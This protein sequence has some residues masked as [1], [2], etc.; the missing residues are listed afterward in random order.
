MV[1][2][3]KVN[4]PTRQQ[5]ELEAAKGAE[6]RQQAQVI[7]EAKAKAAALQ[8]SRIEATTVEARQQSWAA[9]QA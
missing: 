9:Q 1:V 8:L 4:A 5:A 6:A 7:A 2:E 3:V